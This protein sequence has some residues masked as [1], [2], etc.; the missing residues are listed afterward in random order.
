MAGTNMHFGLR[1]FALE[2]F[3]KGDVI[4]LFWWLHA[5]QAEL[6]LRVM[7]VSLGVL[8]NPSPQMV[9]LDSLYL[10]LKRKPEQLKERIWPL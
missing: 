3:C 5:L 10:K 2:V 1:S 7:L 6:E 9:A 4:H 8:K